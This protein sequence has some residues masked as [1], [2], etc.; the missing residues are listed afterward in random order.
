MADSQPSPYRF[1]IV[2]A[3][4]LAAFLS[5][6]SIFQMAGLAGYIIPAAGLD[7]AKFGLVIGISILTAAVLGM[8]LGALGDRVGVKPVA[9]LPDGSSYSC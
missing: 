6:F 4:A 3:V 2:F 9:Y 7:S 1:V 8:P 5:N